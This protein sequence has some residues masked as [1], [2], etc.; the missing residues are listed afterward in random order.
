M[1]DIA[2]YLSEVE[3]AL[4][5]SAAIAEYQII[6][7][8]ANSDDGYIRIRA[9]LTND[10]FLEAAEYFI[11]EQERIVTVNYRYQWM[12]GTQ[13]ALRRRWDNIPDHPELR[14]FPHHNM[15][16]DDETNVVTGSA[17]N[18]INLIKLLERELA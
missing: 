16:M 8:W 13:R 10:D 6:R 18:L 1:S 15:H 9:T 7:S 4:V 5:S 12:D 11:L 14:N 17:L 3:L 2:T